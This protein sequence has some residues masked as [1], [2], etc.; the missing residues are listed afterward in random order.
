MICSTNVQKS[1]IG[2]FQAF[3][4]WRT[5][6]N[7]PLLQLFPSRV[8]SPS[9]RW[10]TSWIVPKIGWV[11]SLIRSDQAHEKNPTLSATLAEIGLTAHSRSLTPQTTTSARKKIRQMI[12]KPQSHHLLRV[13]KESHLSEQHQSR[14]ISASMQARIDSVA[15]MSHKKE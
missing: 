8:T 14:K 12:K 9:P 10:V 1:T 15:L 2:D 4:T 13:I 3:I 7:Q 6:R 11:T 5:T